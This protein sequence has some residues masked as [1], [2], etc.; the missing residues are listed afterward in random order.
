MRRFL[1]LAFLLYLCVP[2]SA[3]AVAASNRCANYNKTDCERTAVC[4]W[5]TTTLTCELTPI[6]INCETILNEDTCNASTDCEWVT[7]N[8]N[9]ACQEKNEDPEELTKCDDLVAN[10][11]ATSPGCQLIIEQGCQACSNGT[12]NLGGSDSK[13]C[14]PCPNNYP[15]TDTSSGIGATSIDGCYKKCDETCANKHVKNGKYSMKNGSPS[16]AYYDNYCLCTLTCDTAPNWCDGYHIDTTGA[17]C[18]PNKSEPKETDNYTYFEYTN[19]SGVTAQYIT[20]CK[21]ADQHFERTGTLCSTNYGKCVD[22]THSCESDNIINANP[23]TGLIADTIKIT[24]N[25]EWKGNTWDYSDCLLTAEFSMFDSETWGTKT[26]KVQNWQWTLVPDSTT[27]TKCGAGYYYDKNKD[28]TKCITVEAGYYS[29]ANDT[30]SHPC[31]PGA[32]SAVGA[33]VATECH[34]KLGETDGTKFCNGDGDCFYL[35]K[36]LFFELPPYNNTA[37]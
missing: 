25:V 16:E 15:Y 4:T 21:R 8:G 20:D 11:C 23:P 3:M 32:T 12:Y 36:E 30:N 29:P 13:G 24:G 7:L 18:A 1:T 22:N 35:P 26:Y 27:I 33:K 2:T 37:F 6:T 14:T 34:I 9:G 17:A 10:M 31:P 28:S 19:Q 5:N